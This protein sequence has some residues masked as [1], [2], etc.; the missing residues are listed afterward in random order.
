MEDVDDFITRAIR[1]KPRRTQKRTIQNW[2]Y[3]TE[4]DGFAP[5]IMNNSNKIFIGV[6]D[7]NDML[8]AEALQSRVLAKKNTYYRNI[9]VST[10]RRAWTTWC[11]KQFSNYLFFQSNT[12]YG[13]ILDQKTG[14]FIT[15]RVN[16]N[17]TEASIYGDIEFVE[18]MIELI[19]GNFDEVVS[20]IEWVYSSQGH[21]AS[22]PLNKTRLPIKEMYPFL[23]GE[24]LESFYDRFM[25]SSS[26]I[27]LLIGP[28]GTGKTTFIRGLL[29]HTNSSAYVTYDHEILEK[30][31]IF[32]EFV[33]SE[34]SIMVLEDSDNFLKPRK[35]GNTMMAKF[36]NLGDG[37]VTTKGKKLIFSTNLPS[38]RDVDNALTRPG[39]CFGILNFSG[40]NYDEAKVLQKKLKLSH[41]L[42]VKDNHELYT[43]AEIFSNEQVVHDN[44]QIG[45]KVGFI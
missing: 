19:A 10:N 33:G 4:D 3:N 22:V 34:S 6:S 28:P 25:D 11:E 16:S 8:V 1:A 29:S 40:L 38:I 13:F 14:E 18:D 20:H 7:V 41:E 17:S 44:N 5:N 2:T 37:L 45:R 15:Y 30:D 26:N 42:Q 32:A 24:S 43:L 27:L 31:H 12:D 35:D 36:L 39:R 23:K 9:Q 21:S